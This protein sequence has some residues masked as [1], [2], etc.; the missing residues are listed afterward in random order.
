MA[1]SHPATYRVAIKA[2]NNKFEIQER[3]W[4][5]PERGQV[6]VKVL[7]SGVCHSDV[8]CPHGGQPGHEICGD[9]VA[10]HE[11]EKKW[12]VGDR[13]GSGWHGGHCGYCLQCRR[14]NFSICENEYINALSGPGGYAEYVTLRTEGIAEVPRDM[15][16]ADAAINMCA[17][18]TVA[19]GLR[20]VQGIRPG[21]VVLISGLGG[22]AHLGIQ[23]SKKS[24][25]Y[26]VVASRGTSKKALAEELGADLYIDSQSQDLA[27]EVQKLGG[28]KVIM[29]LAPSG[30]AMSSL[31]PALARDGTYLLLAIPEDEM[32]VPI[33]PLIG[34]RAKLVGWPAGSSLD[35]EEINKF[36]FNN[37]IK[38]YIQEF[39]LDQVDEAYAA[40]I[41]GTARFRSV[42]VFN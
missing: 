21:D 35:A 42:L 17:G 16:P 3:Q 23:F 37:G 27:A 8:M 20:N 13:V 14:G 34:K 39:S 28:A 29:G 32:S 5:D 38:G 15:R 9:V 33:L 24:G 6:V 10:V 4:K 26:T 7:A 1:S 25:Y 12:K 22:L 18:V 31:I 41:N 40:M 2:D 30:K 11:D 36:A 19:N